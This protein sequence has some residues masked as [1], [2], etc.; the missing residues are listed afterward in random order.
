MCRTEDENRHAN[1]VQHDGG[2]V[3]HVV[4][5]V[6]PAREKTV[7]VAED[8]LGPQI[9][10]AFAW[11]TVREF[12]DGDA[13]R[14]EK[15]KKRNDPKPDGDAAVCGDGWDNVQVEN[16]NDKEQNEVPAAEDAFEMKRF[17]RLNHWL[18]C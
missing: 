1:K 17:V 2:N 10:A 15:K 13:L 14:P 12:D 6:A 7:K 18:G 4:G 11:V 9:N 16:G 3:H 5:P 8:F